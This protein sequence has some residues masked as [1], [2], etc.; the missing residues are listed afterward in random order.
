MPKDKVPMKGKV[1]YV[2][3]GPDGKIKWEHHTPENTLT[4]LYDVMVADRISGGTDALLT[5]GHCGTGSGQGASD[6]NLDAPFAE[7]RTAVQSTTQG[8]GASDND[9]VIVVVFGAGVCT[10]A[11]EEFCLASDI[12]YTTADMK[13]YDDSISKVKA[14]AD[15]LTATWTGTFGAS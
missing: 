8:T 11:I 5:H 9:V 15:T 14:A 7:N 1:D 13:A 2:C 3:R 10:G 4:E 12:T 6:T